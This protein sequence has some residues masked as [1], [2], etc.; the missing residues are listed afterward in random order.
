LRG[1]GG[2]L[3]VSNNGTITQ[4]YTTGYVAGITIAGATVA[5]NGTISESFV[6]GPMDRY[7]PSDVVGAISD[8]N[9]GTIANNV[10]WDV[11]TTTA[12]VGTVSGTPVLAA[13]GLTTAQMSTASSFGPTWSFT[14][15]GTWVI[16]AGGTHPILRWQQAVK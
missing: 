16:P 13:N 8:N 4:S 10:F 15:D 5:N 7:F 2:G 6:S 14:P 1:N 11:Q 12:N 3:A 9:A